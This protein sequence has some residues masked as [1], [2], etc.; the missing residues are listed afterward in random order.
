MKRQAC[1]TE[2]RR[3]LDTNAN[4]GVGGAHDVR[5]LVE[6][7]ARR[8]VLE[9][10]ELLAVKDTL[11]SARELSRVFERG[12][13]T[14]PNLTEI[15]VNLPPPPGIMDII[16]RTISDRGEV[17]DSASPKL[18]SIR[19]EIKIAHERLMTR[20]QK[21]V[22]DSNIA[23]DAAGSIDY[24]AQRALCDTAAG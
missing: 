16:T 11:I 21:M 13:E 10:T 18:A 14:Y 7:A 3:L 1:T 2:A 17:L 20:L 12:A 5:P 6:R 24:T 4:V 23:P 22:T 8:G 9:P 15:A 19:S